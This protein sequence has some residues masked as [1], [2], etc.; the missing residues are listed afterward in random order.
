M[1]RTEMKR[2]ADNV[3]LGWVKLPQLKEKIKELT[4]Q[5]KD[6]FI[7]VLAE[8]LRNLEEEYYEVAERHGIRIF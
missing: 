4:E 7:L 3:M 1:T 2:L 8:K 6:E 5:E